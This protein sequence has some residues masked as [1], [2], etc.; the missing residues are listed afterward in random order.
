MIGRFLRVFIFLFFSV[1]TIR[2]HAKQ[3]M[4]FVSGSG[5]Q[6]PEGC[7]ANL[8]KGCVVR[9][10][11]GETV[12]IELNKNTID[13]DED[14]V[15]RIDEN[16]GISLVRGG[17][18][19]LAETKQKV[20]VEYGVVESDGFFRVMKDSAKERVSGRSQRV[21]IQSLKGFVQVR[22][23]GEVTGLRIDPGEE[24]WVSTVGANGR[25][26]VGSPLPIPFKQVV[27][28]WARVFR[29]SK[30]DFAQE[31]RALSLRWHQAVEANA[32]FHKEVVERRLASIE[33]SEKI[34][35]DRRLKQQAYRRGLRELFRRKTL[36]DESVDLSKSE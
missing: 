17:V 4:S 10:S 23:L 8:T 1:V 36:Y 19:I 14:S 32:N 35:R 20:S 16:A 24:N 33:R 18:W 22:P 25:A 34:E 29:G 13:L 15:V 21:H 9:S 6:M 5:F 26:T 3:V 2:V 28:S 27:S 12:R 31:V 7:L 30:S 11:N